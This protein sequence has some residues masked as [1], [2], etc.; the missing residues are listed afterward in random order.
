MA[1]VRQ[2]CALALS[3]ALWAMAAVA[4][5]QAP[6]TAGLY[7]R[8]VLVV[9]AGMHN[10][11]IWSAAADQE[12]RWAVT[13]SDDKTVRVWS[14]TDGGLQRTIRLPAGPGNVGEAR[15]VAISPDGALIAAGGWTRTIDAEHTQQIYLFDRDTG[16]LVRR[17]E[18]LPADVKHLAFSPDGVRLAA[19]LGGGKGLRVYSRQTGWAEAA[20]DTDYGDNSYGADFAAD[21]WLATTSSDGKVRLYASDLGGSIEPTRVIEATGGEH[22]YLPL[23]S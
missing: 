5:D 18:G 6:A 16:T 3:L 7:D 19:M 10:A 15:A 21:G 8:P 2:G 17:I 12:G 23:H 1:F 9:D 13:G 22:P 20:R 14:L 11:R 4:E